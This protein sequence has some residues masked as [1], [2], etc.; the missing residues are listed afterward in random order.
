MTFSVIAKIPVFTNSMYMNVII[1]N[2]KFYRENQG[3]KI[4]FY[5]IMDNHIH[6]IASHDENIG[7]VIQNL[8]KFTAKEILGL[9]K[10]DTREWILYLMRYYKKKYK[11][12][13]QYQ[14]WQEGSHPQMILSWDMLKQK[15]EY[16]H[17][18][19]VKRG[20]VLEAEDWLY[21]SARNV[22]GMESVFEVDI[23]EL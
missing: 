22:A 19:P 11:T 15:A 16:I 23:V 17:M 5:V 8:K 13:S 2:F 7:Y 9:L 4:Y 1:D 18:N 21:S 3:L 12:R 20:L 10:R 14:F 6:L